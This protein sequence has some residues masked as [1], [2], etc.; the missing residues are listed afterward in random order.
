MWQKRRNVRS[1]ETSHKRSAKRC[2]GCKVDLSVSL[3]V[4]DGKGFAYCDKCWQEWR[5]NSAAKPSPSPTE[6]PAPN[7]GQVAQPC[8]SETTAASNVTSKSTLDECREVAEQLPPV[9]ATTR[10]AAEVAQLRRSDSGAQECLE[11]AIAQQSEEVETLHAIFGESLRIL[12]PEGERPLVLRLELPAE[13]CDGGCIELR[14][15]TEDGEVPAGAVEVLPPVALMFALPATYPFENS[16]PLALA[17]QTQHLAFTAVTEIEAELRTLAQGRVG[18]VVLFEIAS[19]LQERLVVSRQLLLPEDEVGGSMEIAMRLLAFDRRACEERRQ[20]KVQTC[21]VCLEGVPGF[22]GVFLKCGH[23]GCRDCLEQMVRLH[24]SE[25]DVGALRCFVGGCGEAFSHEVVTDILGPDSSELARWEEVSLQKCL[26]QMQDVV[27]CP[28]CDADGLGKRSPC[29][30]DD[31]HTASCAACGF[32]FCGRCRGAFHPGM[33]C[34]SPDDRMAALEVRAR[35]SGREA[36]AAQSELLTLRHLAKTSKSCPKCKM[37][38]EKSE[39]C[40][41]VTCGNCKTHFCWRC[42]KEIKGYDHFATSECRLFDDE[43]IRRWN[44]KVH[45]VGKAEARAHEARF[46]AQFVDPAELWRQMRECP[47]CRA[48]VARDGK[49]NHMRCYACLTH[50]CSQ[51][52]EV[53]PKKNPGDHFQRLRICPQHSSD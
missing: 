18:E 1:A 37:G 12:S 38:I 2:S 32:V 5:D 50:F 26:D 14:I 43:E 31:D 22:R 16:S 7:I 36:E 29:I 33:E 19:A 9:G 46:L 6:E 48:G 25:A 34:Q 11:E 10:F 20:G 4:D 24:I 15:S 3:T 49:N 27:Y 30:Q 17:V 51:C 52:G 21:P 39:G 8:S 44:Q 13:A 41:K 28:R 42:N 47:R 53:L 35:G 23:F 40:S 45:Q